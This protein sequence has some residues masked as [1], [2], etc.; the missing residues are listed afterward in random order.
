MRADAVERFWT[1]L[2]CF[3]SR[4]WQDEIVYDFPSIAKKSEQLQPILLL[5]LSGNTE[6]EIVTRFCRP[7]AVFQ[8]HYGLFGRSSSLKTLW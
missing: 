1:F 2:E 7:I 3:D 4:G 6:K 5:D 8:W